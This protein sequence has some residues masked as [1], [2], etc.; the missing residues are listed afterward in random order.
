MYTQQDFLSL[1]IK[2][3]KKKEQAFI[4]KFKL[5]EVCEFLIKQFHYR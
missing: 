5:F 3:K 2:K 1:N 4:P